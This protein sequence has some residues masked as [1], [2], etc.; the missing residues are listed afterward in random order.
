MMLLV[1]F[2]NGEFP[3]PA[4]QLKNALRGC[5]QSRRAGLEQPGDLERHITLVHTASAEDAPQEKR[6]V[7]FNLESVEVIEYEADE[8]L[9]DPPVT[10]ASSRVDAWKLKAM[11]SALE[12]VLPWPSLHQSFAANLQHQA[13]IDS[14]PSVG[15]ALQALFLSIYDADLDLPSAPQPRLGRAF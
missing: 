2:C 4:Q 5:A 3:S 12:A 8:W 14:E 15:N 13:F 11:D 7:R 6:R 10:A 1:H 9:P